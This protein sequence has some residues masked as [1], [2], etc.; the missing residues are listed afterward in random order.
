MKLNIE[1]DV[2]ISDWAPLDEEEKECFL[3]Q[4]KEDPQL[5]LHSNSI[6]DEVGFCTVK[7]AK[8]EE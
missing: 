8:I 6:A 7:K 2:D 5:I 1:L 3:D 4:I